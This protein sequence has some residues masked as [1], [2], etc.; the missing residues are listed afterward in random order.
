[1]LFS[2]LCDYTTLTE[3]TD[4]E[5]TEELRREVETIAVRIVGRHGGT[6]AQVYGDGILAV[7][8]YPTPQE[9][10]A[11]RAIEAAIELHEATRS[12]A[13]QVPVPPGFTVRLHSGVH[14]GLVFARQGDELHGRYELTGDA[15]NTTARLCSAAGRDEI[16]VSDEA[17][18]GIA[19]FFATTRGGPL[20]LK[21]KKD[22]VAAHRVLGR[23]GIQ[24]RYEARTREGLTALVGRAAEIEKLLQLAAEAATGSP[25]V[26]L[27]RG[28]PGVG[29]TRILEEL[30]RRAAGEGM[31]VLRGG[32]ESYGEMPPLEPFLQALRLL[33]GLAPSAPHEQVTQLV[34]DGLQRIDPALLPHAETCAR[35]L[36]PRLDA[37][38]VA[39]DEREPVVATLA[40]ILL[41]LTRSKP[42]LLVLDDWQWADDGSRRVLT[43]LLH[44]Y[45][46][47]RVFVLVGMRADRPSDPLLAGAHVLALRPFCEDESAT[48]IR[49]MRPRI[50]DL[51]VAHAIHERCG[52]NPLFLEELCSVL[53]DGVMAGDRVLEASGIPATL[54]GLIQARVAA[55]PARQVAVLRAASVIG[56]EFSR[57]LLLSVSATAP[58]LRGGA[59]LLPGE[60]VAETLATLLR[61]DLIHP[62]EHD[63]RLRFKH[64]I[65][66][67]VIYESVRIAERRELHHAVAV[68]LEQRAGSG[69]AA[70]AYEALAYHYRGSHDGERA[71]TYAALAGDKALLTSTL[72]RARSQYSTALAELDRLP[73]TPERKRK[74]LAICWKWAAAYVYSPSRDQLEVLRKAEAY[75]AEL[76]DPSDQALAAHWR[77]WLLYV[78][79]EYEEATRIA[80]EGIA[81]SE[82]LGDQRMLVQLWSTM[83]QCLHAAGEHEAAL[84]WLERSIDTKR[85]RA[86]ARGGGALALGYAYALGCKASLHADRGEFD[87]AAPAIAEAVAAVEGSGH[88]I[89][90]SV[91]ALQSTVLLYRGWWAQAVAAADQAC[92]VAER[93]NSAYVFSISSGFRAYARFM[94][95]SIPRALQEMVQAV[96]W[97]ESRDTGLF[98]SLY[99]GC[100][101]EALVSVGSYEEARDYALRALLR[102]ER[103]DA[104]GETM[105]YRALACVAMATSSRGAP[106]AHDLIAQAVGSAQARG[107]QRDRLIS[108]LLAAQLFGSGEGAVDI[109]RLLAEF[110]RM[111]MAF[112]AAQARALLS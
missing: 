59:S 2:D 75:A 32:C 93:V 95:E 111:G 16:L 18:R 86:K 15:V 83:G 67:E 58:A 30:Q 29:K 103:R 54:Q 96:E 4:P 51:G 52:G 43:E 1:M 42:L 112:H 98:I 80:Q 48:M 53:P 102:K 92:R 108:E 3:Q 12:T 27:L 109:A 73:P 9:D 104:L 24:T 107:S 25:R 70:D 22:P 21:G 82:R 11:R 61:S 101:A 60:D 85:A 33:F 49:M 81:L 57:S 71:A 74:W 88:A 100:L 76:G 14:A 84:P 97:L 87:Q 64:G 77:S 66:R 44:D 91:L 94:S 105:A 34:H 90:G 8:G 55:L 23:S 50:L 28:D 5:E 78:L 10:D 13:W 6:V 89:E 45:A 40:S 46:G 37:A 63:D 20:Q 99:Y 79:G 19:A 65:T 106:K 47:Q 56:N 62:T 41:A 39:R 110:E 7:F 72:D 35:L 31:R 69:P 36:A 26:A 17:L 68:A 38:T